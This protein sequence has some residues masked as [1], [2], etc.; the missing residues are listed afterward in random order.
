MHG[1]SAANITCASVFL[2]IFISAAF[3]GVLYFVY[4]TWIEA[5]FPASAPKRSGPAAAPKTPRKDEAVATSTAAVDDSWIP[6]HHRVRP[7]A[8]RG[9]S[10]TKN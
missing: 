3:A 7:T 8:R 6:E 10:A 5:L 1:L 2:Y 9:K 4:K